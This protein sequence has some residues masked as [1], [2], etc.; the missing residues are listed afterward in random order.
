[1]GKVARHIEVDAELLAR[2]EEKGV[3]LDHA[4]EE[5]IKAAL[6]RDVPDRPMTVVE[7][8][9]Q[10]RQHPIDMEA[11]ARQWAE[12]NAEAIRDHQARIE[13][14]GVFGEDLRTW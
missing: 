7:A 4:L 9:E 6:S 13:K 3:Q 1:M 12:E 10:L 11:A 14:Y 5:G 8:A 2:A